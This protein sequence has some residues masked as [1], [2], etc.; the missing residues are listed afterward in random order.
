MTQSK[1]L[2]GLILIPAY[3]EERSVASVVRVALEYLPVLV[4]DD[5]STDDTC[6]RARSAGAAVLRNK[7]NLGKGASLQVGFR[8]ALEHAIDFV[9]TLDADGQHDPKE[10]PLF[11]KAYAARRTD[12]IIGQRD[13]SEMPPVRRVSNTLGTKLFSWA[14]GRHIPDNQSGYRL[15]SRRLM[16]VLCDSVEHGFEFELEMILDCLLNNFSM[17]WVPIRTIYA[18]EQSHI[19]P[20]RHVAKFVQVCLR[21]KRLLI[22]AR[23]DGATR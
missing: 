11:L 21:A 15:L 17:A 12:L 9:L 14:V 1:N 5:G 20:L 19:R 16:A 4:V 3:D 6:R 13:F 22:K 2:N 8:Y 18:H 10:I 7:V 23:N